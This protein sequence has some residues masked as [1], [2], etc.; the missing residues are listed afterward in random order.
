MR[1]YTYSNP[2]TLT[3]A[4]FWNEIAD[5]PH[6]CV[7]QTLVQGLEAIYNRESFQVLTTI[8]TFLNHFYIEWCDSPENDIK[9]YIAISEEL[10]KVDD[11]KLASSFKFN[12][13]ELM[14]AVKFLIMLGVNPSDFDQSQLADEQIGM[15]EMIK[16]LQHTPEWEVAGELSGKG[17]AELQV[18][19]MNLLNKDLERAVKRQASAKTNREN[20]MQKNAVDHLKARVEKLTLEYDQ[21]VKAVVFHGI[22]RFTPLYTK[23]LEHLRSLDIEVIFLINYVPKYERM[24]ETW[25]NVYDW[26]K[27][28]FLPDTSE[29]SYHENALGKAMG[30]LLEG[31]AA[32]TQFEGV[33]ATRFDNLTTFADYVKKVFSQARGEENPDIENEERKRDNTLAKMKEQFYAPDNQKINELLRSYFPEQFGEK[34][35]LSYPIG[36]FILALY[37]MW[38]DKERTLKVNDSLLKE[39]LSINYFQREGRSSPVEIYSNIQLYTKD[40]T[41][42]NEF[43]KRLHGLIDEV[44]RLETSNEHSCPELRGFSFYYVSKVDL[45]YLIDVMNDIQKITRELFDHENGRLNYKEHY[46]KLVDIISSRMLKTSTLTE[47][48]SELLTDIINK[49]ENIDSL[50]VE[51]SIEDLKETIHFYLNR[52]SH[53]DS[54]HWIV[55]NFEQLDGGVLLSRKPGV[56]SKSEYH[57]A[58]LS[59]SSMKKKMNDLLPW[60]LNEQFFK[61]YL[62]S[63]IPN[64]QIVLKSMKEYPSFLRYSL[65]YTTYYLSNK[66]NVSYIENSEGEKETPY[67]LLKL[68]EIGYD[69]FEESSLY[70]FNT[71]NQGVTSVSDLNPD[72]VNDI[73]LSPS[74]VKTF[75]LC[76]Y[77]YFMDY[78]LEHGGSFQSEYQCKLYYRAILLQKSWKLLSGQPY[79]LEFIKKTVQEVNKNELR[80]YFPFW[81]DIDFVDLEA[82]VIK[83]IKQADGYVSPY[84]ENYVQ[85][86]LD[87]LYA[88]V[89]DED[90]QNLMSPVHRLRNE[91]KKEEVRSSINM[92]YQHQSLFE[93]EKVH[94][95]LCNFCKNREICLHHFKVAGEEHEVE[96]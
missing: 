73:I 79:N 77:R 48:E 89:N 7:S 3:T 8:D 41:S 42:I 29:T 11:H 51:G 20:R 95:S 71:G 50:E 43:L 36:Q 56:T 49:F 92:Y 85:I 32:E 90:K 33:T 58:I 53:E 57:L 34:H 14:D 4:S 83:D 70:R 69:Q 55:R 35:F 9:Q 38:D 91:R 52:R 72:I 22:H 59:D 67:F 37:N 63:S 96:E 86:R 94:P 66:I 75:T 76:S 23:L 24:Y 19:W 64:L 74:Q 88:Q 21:P 27:L 28:T 2:F 78:V 60:P 15:L 65:F 80:D 62:H 13:K 18:T 31:K 12:Q 47:K 6:L 87:F 25:R 5:Y 1:I 68:L 16:R 93:E 46:K 10:S 39:C 17:H 81:R 84:D 61:A 54:A 40:V 30:D 26:T 82:W 45:E 44:R